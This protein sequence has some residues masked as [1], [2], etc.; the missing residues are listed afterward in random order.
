MSHLAQAANQIKQQ[1]LVLQPNHHPDTAQEGM[2]V[3]THLPALCVV[4]LGHG[5]THHAAVLLYKHLS[6]WAALGRGIT[7]H[8]AVLL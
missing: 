7:H 5:I 4:A 8:A 6:V 2:V 3:F 1:A